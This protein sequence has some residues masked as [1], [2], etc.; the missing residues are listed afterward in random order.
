MSKY[1]KVIPGLVAKN[2]E[3]DMWKSSEKKTEIYD[4]DT[5]N[6]REMIEKARKFI[7][8]GKTL[9]EAVD[10][11]MQ[12]DIIKK[13]DYWAKNNLDVRQ[14]VMNLVKPKTRNIQNQKKER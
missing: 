14:C 3:H 9:D 6:R 5:Q 4:Q 2:I 12:D 10:L 13:F 11:I 7:E 1:Q 8:E